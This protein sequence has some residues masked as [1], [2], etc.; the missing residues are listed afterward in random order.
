MKLSEIIFLDTETTQ[1]KGGRLVQLAAM[2]YGDSEPIVT[3]Y[4]PAEP[5][6][7]EAMVVHGITN[8]EVEALM[9][10]EGFNEKGNEESK[11]SIIVAHNAPFDIDV[12]NREGVPTGKFIDTLKIARL[13]ID[14]PSHSLQYLR[15]FLKL[16]VPKEAGAHDA[17]GDVLI[18]AELFK[19]LAPLMAKKI[20][21]DF[22]AFPTEHMVLNEMVE[23]SSKPMLMRTMLFGKHK[24]ETFEEI[25]KKDKGYLEWLIMQ[26]D[27]TEDLMYTLKTHLGY[28][29]TNN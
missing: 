5:I 9:P 10:F 23:V 11:N 16:N 3:T 17:G 12:M 2:K 24:G 28:M 27:L 22:E 7:I 26:D 20:K 1:K 25:K 14:S 21:K 8:E 6:S 29:E 15:Y 19:Y 18:L 13:L 4:K